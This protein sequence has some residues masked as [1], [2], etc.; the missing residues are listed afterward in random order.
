MDDTRDMEEEFD[1]N[2]DKPEVTHGT[3]ARITRVVQAGKGLGM[4]RSLGG[5]G[6][7]SEQGFLSGPSH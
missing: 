5:G 2:E 7:G 1:G 3:I 4:F 6:E